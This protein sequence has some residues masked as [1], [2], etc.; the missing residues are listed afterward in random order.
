MI[1]KDPIQMQSPPETSRKGKITRRLFFVILLG[2]IFGSV[3]WFY[4]RNATAKSIQA[5]FAL[6]DKTRH[7]IQE[8]LELLKREHMTWFLATVGFFTLVDWGLRVLIPRRMEFRVINYWSWSVFSHRS[9]AWEYV[10]YPR[11]EDD[12]ICDGLIRPSEQ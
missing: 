9:I 3:A 8:E 5:F 11:V 10:H 4:R 12:A 2:A 7:I 1:D 6:E